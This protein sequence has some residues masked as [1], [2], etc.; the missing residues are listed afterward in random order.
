MVANNQIKQDKTSDSDIE[1][2]PNHTR[3]T[4]GVYLATKILK[5]ENSTTE[6]HDSKDGAS[7][8]DTLENTNTLSLN[9]GW[10]KEQIKSCNDSSTYLFFRAEEHE[11]KSQE[12]FDKIAKQELKKRLFEHFYNKLKKLD[13]INDQEQR[14]DAIQKL[15]KEFQDTLTLSDKLDSYITSPATKEFLLKILSLDD[16]NQLKLAAIAITGNASDADLILSSNIGLFE[17]Y[18]DDR[19]NFVSQVTKL[20]SQ[21][22]NGIHNE[23]ETLRE[24]FNKSLK[25]AI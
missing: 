2:Q 7:R 12:L 1:D 8:Q 13:D 22:K 20:H 10:L 15:N 19:A 16:F 23:R 3:S 11:L 6:N 24:Q 4:R 25:T 17:S 5:F 18:I 21:Y 9:T 14:C